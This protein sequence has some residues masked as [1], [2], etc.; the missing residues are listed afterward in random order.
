LRVRHASDR[1]HGQNLLTSGTMTNRLNRLEQRG[2]VV[3]RDPVDARS[4]R[5]RLTALGRR[6]VDKAL[7]ELAA[8]EAA[9]RGSL[10]A[11]ERATLARMPQTVVDPFDE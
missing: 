9:L 11:R 6:Q 10:T 8:R 5:V 3:R 2:L 7:Q 1:L 4:V